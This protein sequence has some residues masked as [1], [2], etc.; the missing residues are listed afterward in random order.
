MRRFREYAIKKYIMFKERKGCYLDLYRIS[1]NEIH[2][3]ELYI[4]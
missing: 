3:S 4:F 1:Q 2:V